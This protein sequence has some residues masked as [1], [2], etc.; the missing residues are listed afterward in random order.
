MPCY[1]KSQRLLEM[2]KDK[3]LL[4]QLWATSYQLYLLEQNTTEWLSLTYLQ[5]NKNHLEITSTA[6]DDL[7][8]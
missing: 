4:E 1:G 2:E 6:I 5:F 7:I 8:E 3:A